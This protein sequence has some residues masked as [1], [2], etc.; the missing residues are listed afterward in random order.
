MTYDIDVVDKS[1]FD[2]IPSQYDRSRDIGIETFKILDPLLP[3]IYPLKKFKPT[4]LLQICFL[5]SIL[6]ASLYPIREQLNG[7]FLL[8]CMLS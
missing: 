3:P 7:F 5:S 6:Q 8:S 4:L 1:T 2:I